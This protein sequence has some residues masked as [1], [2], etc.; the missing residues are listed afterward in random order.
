[1]W[2][3]TTRRDFE[4]NILKRKSSA[5]IHQSSTFANQSIIEFGGGGTNFKLQT[6]GTMMN[7]ENA[8]QLSLIIGQG[9]LINDDLPLRSSSSSDDEEGDDAEKFKNTFLNNKKTFFQFKSNRD[10]N[11]LIK[12]SEE[13]E[14]LDDLAEEDC[15][16]KKT[17]KVLS[18]NGNSDN[19]DDDEEEKE[20][21]PHLRTNL[22]V[23]EELVEESREESLRGDSNVHFQIPM[24]VGGMTGQRIT[25]NTLAQFKISQEVAA[26]AASGAHHG[27]SSD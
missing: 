8:R 20:N 3:E 22:Q 15:F 23:L 18:S 25:V 9:D 26:L 27:M 12:Q 11:L 6:S 7:F 1:M 4:E 16:D 14:Q 19:E 24:N 5:G 2:F 17:P 10:E 13:Q 21:R